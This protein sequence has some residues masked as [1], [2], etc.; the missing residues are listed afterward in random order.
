MTAT[1]GVAALQLSRLPHYALSSVRAGACYLTCFT[2]HLPRSLLGVTV[3][4]CQALFNSL[5]RITV[6]ALR[7]AEGWHELSL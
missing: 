4:L 3:G 7:W 5:S 2:S 6:R 1:Q